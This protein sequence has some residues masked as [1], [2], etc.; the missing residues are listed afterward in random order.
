MQRASHQQE[1]DQ[2]AREA[3]TKRK[4]HQKEK[5]LKLVRQVLKGRVFSL[6]VKLV[7]LEQAQRRLR[8]QKRPR[9][10]DSLSKSSTPRR[11]KTTNPKTKESLKERRVLL[12]RARKSAVANLA[13]V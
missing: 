13:R 9:T 12:L 3:Q 11:L 2:A 5:D 6:R 1:K 4:D 8:V 7:R 10:K